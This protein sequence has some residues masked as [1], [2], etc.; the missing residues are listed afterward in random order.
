MGLA[1]ALA[2]LALVE[3][4]LRLGLGPPPPPVRVLGVLGEKDF[5]LEARGPVMVPI[6]QEESHLGVRPFPCQVDKPRVAVLGGSSVHG[7]SL[8]VG[9]G[10]EF[11][12]R[13]GQRLKIPVLNLA[14]PA[15]DSFDHVRIVEALGDCRADL[16][17]LYAGHNDLGNA[18]FFARYGTVSAGLVAHAQGALEHLQLFVQLRRLVDRR[19]VGGTTANVGDALPP[20]TAAQEQTSLRYLEANLRRIAWLCREA[21]RKLIFVTPVSQLTSPPVDPGC[22]EEGCAGEA[23]AEAMRLKDEDPARAALLLRAA[24][25]LDRIAVRA[26]SAVLALLGR[27]AAEEG[28][29]FIDAEA[30]L[31]RDPD[32]DVPNGGLFLDGLHLSASGHEALAKLIGPAVQAALEAD[33]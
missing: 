24:R 32:F 7:G 5:R 10:G 28:V 31:P 4:G 19:V 9:F 15:L 1:V 26:N 23:Y 21:G 17:V 3:S 29:G 25:D 16:L 14:A 20:L 2:L 18:R 8:G 22:A 30:E 33:P 13:L 12:A 11:P 27:V 6:W